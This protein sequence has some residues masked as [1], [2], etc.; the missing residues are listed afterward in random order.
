MKLAA[1]YTPL[2][3]FCEFVSLNAKFF[4][5]ERNKSCFASFA[6]DVDF[7]CFV[8]Q[9]QFQFSLQ[10]RKTNYTTFFYNNNIS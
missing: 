9:L 5:E 8:L 3:L 10:K 1:Q 6:F 4:A 7:G 2:L